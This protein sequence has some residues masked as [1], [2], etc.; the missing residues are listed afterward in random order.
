MTTT[1]PS[2]GALEAEPTPRTMRLGD[3][4][5]Q[6]ADG[7][8]HGWDTE[9]DWLWTHD[10]DKMWDLAEQVMQ[11]GIQTPV[12]LGDDGRLWDGHHRIGV[13]VALCIEDIPVTDDTDQS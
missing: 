7:E 12:L 11:H 6:Y 5:T 8:E 10:E 1:Q 13:A 9:I 3:F 2:L 4:L